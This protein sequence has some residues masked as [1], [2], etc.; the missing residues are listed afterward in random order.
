MSS[1][2][3]DLLNFELYK[4]NHRFNIITVRDSTLL[5]ERAVLYLNE[6]SR[7]SFAKQT[8]ANFL[9]PHKQQTTKINL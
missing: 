4:W 5:R 8:N 2:I 9:I 6:I 3:C 7:Y 1:R